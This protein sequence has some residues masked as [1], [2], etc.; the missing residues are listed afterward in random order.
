MHVSIYIIFHSTRARDKEVNYL[1]IHLNLSIALAL[2]L[3]TFIGGIEH[4][5]S[6][7]VTC[8]IV[9]ICDWVYKKGSHGRTHLIFGQNDGYVANAMCGTPTTLRCGDKTSLSLY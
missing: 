1:F 2:G 8:R 7:E 3:A 5:V 6:S 4:A 9:K